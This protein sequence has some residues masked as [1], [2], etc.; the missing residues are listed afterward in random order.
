MPL[1][2]TKSSNVVSLRSALEAY[3]EAAFFA[4]STIDALCGSCSECWWDT[5]VFTTNRVGFNGPWDPNGIVEPSVAR[6]WTVRGPDLLGS[7]LQ[8]FI[9]GTVPRPAWVEFHDVENPPK[10]KL[11]GPFPRPSSRSLRDDFLDQLE[12]RALGQSKR[13][14]WVSAR[15][16]RTFKDE[17]YIRIPIRGS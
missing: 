14:L 7:L 15:R 10:K 12:E 17:R 4:R 5:D 8:D 1:R 2:S 16:G 9:L 13:R 3:D 6:S 11:F